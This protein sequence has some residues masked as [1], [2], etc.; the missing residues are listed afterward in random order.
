MSA[1]AYLGAISAHCAEV[2]LA[3]V[4]AGWWPEDKSQRNRGEVMMLIV[5]E[6]AE[7]SVG[8][9]DDAMDDHLPYLPM[10]DVELADTAIRLMDLLGA[11][12][13]EVEI[14]DTVTERMVDAWTDATFAAQPVDVQLMRVVRCVASAMEAHRKGRQF[15]YVTW[16]GCALVA[17][18]AVAKAH[19][20]DLPDVIAQKR[21]YNAQRADHKPENR[22]LPGGKAY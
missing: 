20:I 4:E 6:L 11:D 3:N 9:I 13:D 1:E 19:D 16:L 5:S 15:M 18:F 22:V 21:A 17:T 8:A 10:F 12:M 2:H 7:A 14:G